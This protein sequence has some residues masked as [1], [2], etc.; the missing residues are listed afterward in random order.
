[1]L[2]KVL[3]N[4]GVLDPSWESPFKI[5]EVLTPWGVQTI[6]LKWRANS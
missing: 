2:R 5:A 6:V 4:K 1:M 3:Q